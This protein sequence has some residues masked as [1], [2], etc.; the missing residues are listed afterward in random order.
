M[1][2]TLTPVRGAEAALEQGE[3]LFRERRIAEAEACFRAALADGVPIERLAERLWMCAML[4]GD[5]A[6]A[7]RVSDQVLRR[8]AG[9]SAA[10]LPYHLRWVWD[11]T[12]LAGRDVLIRCYHGLG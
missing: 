10:H 5:F 6:A 2:D 3:S 1:P 4:R 12:P 7:W 11:G 8:R 9:A